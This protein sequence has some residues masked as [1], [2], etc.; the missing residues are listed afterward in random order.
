MDREITAK[1]ERLSHLF[2]EARLLQKRKDVDDKIKAEF[3]WYLCIRTSGFVEFS[4]QFLLSEYFESG[5]D[6][7]PLG[8]FVSNH[9]LNPREFTMRRV[10]KLLDSF[11]RRRSKVQEEIDISKLDSSLQS[12]QT[13]RN[14][15]AHG[16][17]IE[18]TMNDLDA[19]FE[20]VRQVIRMVYDEC[21][22]PDDE[23]RID[24]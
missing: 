19:Y 20:D 18:L 17:D 24:K 23:D 1:E 3:V 10:R 2:S 7:E 8:D 5:T 15:I 16:R 21:N 9:L 4:V 12:L 14:S 22:F 6:R 11:S 13:N